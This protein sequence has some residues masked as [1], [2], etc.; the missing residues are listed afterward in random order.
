MISIVCWYFQCLYRRA[1]SRWVLASDGCKSAVKE[2]TL[3]GTG[4]A[5]CRPSTGQA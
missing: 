5:R 2:L 1:L 3:K 4:A